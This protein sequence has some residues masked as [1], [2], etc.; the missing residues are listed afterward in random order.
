MK[1]ASVNLQSAHACRESSP[2]HP[3]R[4]ASGSGR[5]SAGQSTA[6]RSEGY[7]A[8]VSRISGGGVDVNEQMLRLSLVSDAEPSIYPRRFWH[9]DAS[10]DGPARKAGRHMSFYNQVNISLEGHKGMCCSCRKFSQAVGCL[11]I[12]VAACRCKIHSDRLLCIASSS[13]CAQVMERLPLG[14]KRPATISD[15]VWHTEAARAAPTHNAQS[16]TAPVDGVSGSERMV[17]PKPNRPEQVDLSAAGPQTANFDG[18]ASAS[19]A[20]LTSLP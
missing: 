4:T 19:G 5:L 20:L 10:G 15:L 6:G 7:S 11:S 18:S 9:S 3:A 12:S 14:R 17:N 13:G 16:A 1:Y 2:T 8:E